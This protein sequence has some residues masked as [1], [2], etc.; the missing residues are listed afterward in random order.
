MRKGR[1][2]IYQ[3]NLDFPNQLPIIATVDGQPVDWNKPVDRW[4]E[5]QQMVDK[6][7]H[8]LFMYHQIRIAVTSSW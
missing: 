2:C 3:T 4:G 5:N 8:L 6:Y 1:A 7:D